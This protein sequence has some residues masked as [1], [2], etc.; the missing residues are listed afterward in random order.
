MKRRIWKDVALD[1]PYINNY[2]LA[3]PPRPTTKTGWQI[4]STAGWERGQRPGCCEQVSSLF[5]D[6]TIALQ[7]VT[8]QTLVFVLQRAHSEL[9]QGRW[10]VLVNLLWGKMLVALYVYT[11]HH[12]ILSIPAYSG[13]STITSLYDLCCH[14][15]WIKWSSAEQDSH[16]YD[17]FRNLFP[18]TKATSEATH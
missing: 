10:L 8:T 11:T 9:R 7:Y 13:E 2:V 16:T 17:W 18:A 5:T 3:L 6:F 15:S 4:L 14:D 1:T 12:H